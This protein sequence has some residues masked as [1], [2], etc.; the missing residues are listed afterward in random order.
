MQPLH[1]IVQQIEGC[2]ITDCADGYV[3]INRNATFRVGDK[4]AYS[5][6]GAKGIGRY[7]DCAIITED[8]EAIEGESLEDVIIVG[9]VTYEVLCMHEDCRPVI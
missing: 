5:F 2:Y 8:G 3:M 7:F 1:K 9:K 6:L 4:V